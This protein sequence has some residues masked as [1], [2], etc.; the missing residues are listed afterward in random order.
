MR[1]YENHKM[2]LQA[3]VDVRQ[4]LE[5]HAEAEGTENLSLD[6]QD[7]LMRLTTLYSCLDVADLKNALRELEGIDQRRKEVLP[8]YKKAA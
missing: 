2:I 7:I 3:I 1:N 5:S 8:R 6:G 4:E